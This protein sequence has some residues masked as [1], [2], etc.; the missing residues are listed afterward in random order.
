ML[1]AG[2]Y[3][4]PFAR[5]GIPIERIIIQSNLDEEEIEKCFQ[6]SDITSGQYNGNN[7]GV[8]ECLIGIES[9]KVYDAINKIP[10]VEIIEQK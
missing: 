1:H 4:A 5:K 10:N 9:Q 2:L 6:D 7:L 8:E 3:A